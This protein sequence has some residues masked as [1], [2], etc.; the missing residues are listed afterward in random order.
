[1]NDN[2]VRAVQ[3]RRL[4]GELLAPRLGGAR[5]AWSEANRVVSERFFEPDA[6]RERLESYP[7]L[8]ELYRRYLLDWLAGMCELVGVTTPS[9]EDAVELAREVERF[10]TR[11]VRA[12]FPGAVDAIRAL[13]A[14]SH[15]LH[16]AS[17]EMSSE[18]EGYLSGMGVRELFGK[19]YGPDLVGVTK[20]GP[21]YYERV[22]ADAGVRP[23]DSLVVDDSPAAAGWAREAG[24]RT[25]L[26]LPAG[27]DGS[28]ADLTIRSLAELPRMFAR[29]GWIG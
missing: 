14:G 19:L 6:W 8:G 22:F 26:V 25:V 28:P 15:A 21:E 13:H 27:T 18:L 2:V 11:R 17:G 3:W 20:T 16:T 24:A 9:E 4:V 23:S 1:M 29:C 10:V 7:E 5:E 12:A